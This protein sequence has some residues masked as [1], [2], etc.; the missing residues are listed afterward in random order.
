M[1]GEPLDLV[2]L[3]RARARAGLAA[4]GPDPLCHLKNPAVFHAVL[5]HTSNIDFDWTLIA[6]LRHAMRYWTSIIAQAVPLFASAFATTTIAFSHRQLLRK[7]V[8]TLY[9]LAQNVLQSSCYM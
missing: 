1:L 5:S 3:N 9:R 2:A 4:I 6:W 8:Q 7:P